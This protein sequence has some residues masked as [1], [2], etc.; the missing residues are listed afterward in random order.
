MTLEMADLK[1]EYQYLVMEQVPTPTDRK[2]MIWEVTSRSS[3]AVLGE[4]KWFGRWRQYC[5]W[6]FSNTVFNVGCLEDIQHFIEQ[7][8]EMRRA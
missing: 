6:P 8:M 1:K 2:T 3:S 5:F 7:L 4:I